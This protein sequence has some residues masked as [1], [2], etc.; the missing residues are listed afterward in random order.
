[1]FTGELEVK[2]SFALLPWEGQHLLSSFILS[3][4]FEAGKWAQQS[5]D[6]EESHV[7]SRSCAE[8][9]PGVW[10]TLIPTV[11][12]ESLLCQA[13][14]WK[15][16]LQWKESDRVHPRG[17]FVSVRWTQDYGRKTKLFLFLVRLV[18]QDWDKCICDVRCGALKR[19]EGGALRG[20]CLGSCA[21]W[22]CWL[23]VWQVLFLV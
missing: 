21:C 2:I 9:M 8:K 14:P 17:P 13:L 16:G 5:P 15:P 19:V 11:F 1:M 4:S 23:Y 3:K 10:H 7:R 12:I 18:E 20:P 22:V 6:P